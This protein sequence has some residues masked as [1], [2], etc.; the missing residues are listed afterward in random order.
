MSASITATHVIAMA[1]P[2]GCAALGG[3]WSE[4]S[5]VVNIAL[6]GMLL[7]SAFAA[8]VG[9]AATGSAW[10]GLFAAI[11]AAAAMGLLHAWLVE[12][13]GVADLL[14]GIGLNLLAMGLTRIGLNALYG[15]SSNSPSVAGFGLPIEPTVLLGIGAVVVT[16]W[17]LRN[18]VFGLHVRACGESPGTARACGVKVTR[19]RILA[20]TIGGAV[21]GIG[22]AALAFDLRQFQSGMT[23]GRGFVALA[24][25]VVSGW[26]PGR[27]AILALAFALLDWLQIAAQEKLGVFGFVV[28]TLPYIATL[29]GLAAVRPGRRTFAP[30]GLGRRVGEA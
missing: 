2:Y 24:L 15:S 8:I 17:V 23:A 11:A 26:R 14:S 19:T 12:C 21:V 7:A 5:G 30:K 16:P 1:A 27:V 18:T 3:V 28:Q 20:V 4:R 10:L 25:V 13:A 6:E 22:G 29:A 9:Q